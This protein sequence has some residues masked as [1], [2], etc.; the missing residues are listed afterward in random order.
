MYAYRFDKQIMCIQFL[1]GNSLKIIAVLTMLI[2]HTCKIVFQWLLSNYW[3]VMVDNGE[4]SWEEFTQIDN[5]IRFDLQSIGS[6]AFPL[7]CFLLA[8]GFQHTRNRK[9]YIGRMFIFA[10]I[11]EVPFDIGFF[12]RYSLIEGTFPAYFKY[13]NVF[14]TLFLGLLAL[15]CIESFS[16]KSSNRTNKIKVAMLQIASVAII[17]VIAEL[18]YCDYGIEGILYIVVFYLY[19]KNRLYQVLMFLLT[20]IIVTGNQPPMCTLLACLIILFY[21]GRRGKI[22]L[23]YFFYAFYPVHIILLYLITLVLGFFLLD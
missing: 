13:Q 14:F 15:V 11:S 10:L 21:N 23:K 9:R 17:S 12:S 1:T 19:R 5:F 20:Y 16:Y 2:D 18:I 4:M 8:E 3:G 22:K 6:M 7:F